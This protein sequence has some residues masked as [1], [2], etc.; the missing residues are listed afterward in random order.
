MPQI[1]T[2]ASNSEENPASIYGAALRTLHCLGRMLKE[3][4]SNK[5][6]RVVDQLRLVQ[7]DGNGYSRNQSFEFDLKIDGN[8]VMK[9]V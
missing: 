7:H 2:L 9:L 5:C 8:G 4:G 1:R 6:G 3:E